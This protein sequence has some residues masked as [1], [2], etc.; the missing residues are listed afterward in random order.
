LS[1]RLH[2]KENL[3][4][5]NKTKFTYFKDYVAGYALTQ[6]LRSGSPKTQSIGEVKMIKTQ[7]RE[8]RKKTNLMRR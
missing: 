1:E 4:A 5:L 6:V 7:R 2:R 8:L 3:K